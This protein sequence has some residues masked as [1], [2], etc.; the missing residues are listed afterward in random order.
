M[1]QFDL[2]I[3]NGRIVDGTGAPAYRADLGLR[4]GR[5]AAIG[6]DLGIAAQQIDAD[7]LLVTPGFVDVH[8]HFDGQATWDERLWPSSQQGVTTAVMGNCGVGFAPC[9]PEDRDT[10]IALMEGV[11]DIPDTALHEGLPWNWESFPEYLRALAGQRYDIDIAALLPHGPLRVYAMG[12]RA[13][14]RE[15]ANAEDIETMQELIKQ[16]LAAGAVVCP[17]RAPWPTAPSRGTS[18]PCTRP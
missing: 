7:G 5:I 15:Q 18:P 12:E 3:R 2:L 17:P 14:R 11:E 1:Q 4:N 9:R 10:L 6:Q 8:T 13:I 16:G